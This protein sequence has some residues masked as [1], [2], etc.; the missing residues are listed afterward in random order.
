MIL[1]SNFTLFVEVNRA[2]ASPV[3][4]IKIFFLAGMLMKLEQIKEESTND[5]RRLRGIKRTTFDVMI[6]ILSEAELV[7][8][9]N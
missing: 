5:F 6:G 3:E 8:Q 4:L 1:L 2:L 7:N 9:I